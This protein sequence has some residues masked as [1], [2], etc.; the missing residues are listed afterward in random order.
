MNC[1]Q[2]RNLSC[3][4]RGGFRLEGVNLTLPK[5]SFAGIIGQNGSG[6]STFLKGVIG[7]LP[8]SDGTVEL[9]GENLH[10]LS[11]KK[12]ARLVAMVSQFPA[13][14]PISVEEYV[15]MGRMPYRKQFQFSYTEEDIDIATRYL[16]LTGIMHLKEKLM[17]ELSG[18]EQQM[19]AIACA[20]TQ[21]PMLLLLDE[22]TSHLDITYQTKIMNLLQ[23]L[24][25]EEGLTVIMIVHDLN[26]G[27]EYCNYLTLMKKGRVFRQGTPQEVLTYENIESAYNTVVIVKTNPVSDKPV[28]F[29]VS[30]RRIEEYNKQVKVNKDL[31]PPLK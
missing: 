20:L 8:I 3:A 21:Q 1:L 24:S 7:D 14:P 19:A 10:A 31:M 28:V 9:N 27:S 17:T 18:G 25:E 6:K 22:P 5:G 15:L 12:R 13:F 30:M 29:P 11:L 16:E 23:Q 26:L 4:Y 2:V